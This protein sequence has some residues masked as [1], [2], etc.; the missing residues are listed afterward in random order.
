VDHRHSLLLIAVAVSIVSSILVG[1]AWAQ[2]GLT[3]Q[4]RQGSVTVAVTP[5]EPI[6]VGEPLKFRVVLDT[7]SV[8]LD[9]IAWERAVVLRS[10]DGS[11]LAPTTI[12]QTKGSGH[13][14]EAVFLFPPVTGRAEVSVVVRN[15]GGVEER[16]FTWPLSTTP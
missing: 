1:G 12:E 3:K 4:D 2:S 14:R 13:H 8:N 15:V 10:A 5:T 16:S 9:G 7:H 6:A 11:E